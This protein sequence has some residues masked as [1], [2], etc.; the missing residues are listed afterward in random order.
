MSLRIYLAPLMFQLAASV[1]AAQ[2]PQ[3][4]ELKQGPFG[5]LRGGILGKPVLF[6]NE[7]D[8]TECHP[9]MMSGRV[10]G[11]LARAYGFKGRLLVKRC[12]EGD[13][14]QEQTAGSRHGGENEFWEEARL[15]RN[16]DLV[17][18]PV[19]LPHETS[20][21][22]GS[23]CSAFFAYWGLSDDHQLIPVIYDLRSSSVT[24]SRSLGKISF[25]TD[26]TGFLPPPAWN[27]N[28]SN[29]AFDASKVN[30]SSVNLGT[31]RSQ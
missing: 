21:S 19:R 29:A 12:V 28:C 11:W 30:R 10:V 27:G 4:L 3:E 17:A 25:E 9:L 7:I 20:F 26:N 16:G 5:H 13:P 31:R 23:F 24:S 6:E 22:N 15:K 2:Q 1:A 18:S 14:S 8:T